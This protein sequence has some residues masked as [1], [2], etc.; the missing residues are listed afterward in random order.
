MLEDDLRAIEVNLSLAIFQDDKL[1]NGFSGLFCLLGQANSAVGY[2]LPIGQLGSV[3][4]L[5]MRKRIYYYVTQLL[6]LPK[7]SSF[8]G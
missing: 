2:C 3:G 4:Y 1:K 8:T 7:V 6:G 5:L